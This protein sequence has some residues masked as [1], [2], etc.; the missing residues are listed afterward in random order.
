M[1]KAARAHDGVSGAG[2]KS[3]IGAVVSENRRATAV[4]LARTDSCQQRSGSD[5]HIILHARRRFRT[6][7]KSFG[8]TW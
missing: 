7:V 8:A 3:K 5:R 6:A 2:V 1:V 4:K